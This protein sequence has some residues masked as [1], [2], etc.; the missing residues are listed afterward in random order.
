MKRMLI[1][2]RKAAEAPMAHFGGAADEGAGPAEFVPAAQRR[3]APAALPRLDE[4]TL[5]AHFG[6]LAQ[7]APPTAAGPAIAERAEQ[8]AG[9]VRFHPQQSADT[10]QG[11]LEIAHAAARSLAALTGLDRFTLQPPSL[12]AAERAGLLVA[13]AY[14]AREEPERKEIVAP[15]ESTALAAAESLGLPAHPVP[16]LPHGGLDLDALLSAVGERTAAV[17]AGWLTPAGAFERQ[18]GAIGEVA[19]AH[20]ALFCVDAR[21][22]GALAGRT[23]LAEAGADVAWLPLAELC[24]MATTAALGVR[25]PLTEFLPRPLVGKT[26]GGFE[27]DDD[28]PHSI[29]RLALMPANALDALALFAQTSLLGEVGLR[30]RAE[31]TALARARSGEY[32]EEELA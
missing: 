7:E 1:T 30:A 11:L 17:V 29:G 4:D 23:R 21:G 26:R 20:G 16:R 19:R 22:L 5:R 18:L 15:A 8:Q 12:A 31:A 14:L 32:P 13:R 25:A 10:V 24:P 27:L 28:L 6:A 2:E 3:R 9:L